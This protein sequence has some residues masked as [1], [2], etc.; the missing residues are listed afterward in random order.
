MYE[1][2]NWLKQC[3]REM[4]ALERLWELGVVRWRDEERYRQEIDPFNAYES[5]GVKLNI[6]AVIR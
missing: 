3:E 2:L 5:E 1:Y 6:I 4:E